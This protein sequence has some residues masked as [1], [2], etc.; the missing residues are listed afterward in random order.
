MSVSPAAN[1]A[2][3]KPPQWTVAVLLLA[4]V[5]LA[6]NRRLVSGVDCPKWDA[7]MFF[8]PFQMLVAD[9]ARAG[10]FL[11]WNPWLNGGSPDYA[12]PQIGS[13]S[14]FAVILG[15]LTGGT[16]A[17]FRVYWLTIWLWGGV[18]VI[19]LGRHLGA[20]AWG[21]CAIAL[22]FAFSGFY[23]GHAEHTSTLYHFLAAIHRVAP[24][25]GAVLRL[26]TAVEA[27]RVNLSALG[28]YQVGLLNASFAACGPSV[29]GVVLSARNRQGRAQARQRCS[30]QWRWSGSSCF[31]IRRV[32]GRDQLRRTSRVLAPIMPSKTM[33]S[34]GSLS[35]FASPYLSILKG[36]AINTLAV[37]IFR[38][39]AFTWGD[40]ARHGAVALFG[41]RGD[42]GG[43]FD[44]SCC[45]SSVRAGKSLPLRGWL[46]LR[47]AVDTSVTRECSGMRSSVVVLAL[48]GARD[49]VKRN[50]LAPRISRVVAP[51][52][53]HVGCGV[54]CVL[55]GHGSVANHGSKFELANWHVG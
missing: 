16:E 51:G 36:K 22:G 11:L 33:R 27:G 2:S 4:T 24:G 15:L 39:A 41:G 37:P 32:H 18:G 6:A 43:S 13:F 44:V 46:R 19:L 26:G 9:H 40:R 17:G 7:D 25:C 50:R 54:G 48:L 45:C 3:D 55:C 34:I 23:T 5:L 14:P 1:T 29:D 47:S 10:T 30:R 21:A 35:T 42:G 52:L 53:S 8:A 12:E 28:G 49:I 20:P 31:L 38:P